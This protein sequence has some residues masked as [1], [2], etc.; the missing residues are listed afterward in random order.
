[1][2]VHN[3][4]LALFILKNHGPAELA[5]LDFSGRAGQLALDGGCRPDEV[6]VGMEGGVVIHGELGALVSG[7]HAPD[8]FLV[9]F[10]AVVFERRDIKEGVRA[11]RI[12]LRGVGGIERCPAVPDLLQVSLIGG[13]NGLRF[14]G[15]RVVDGSGGGEGDASNE[16]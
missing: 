15:S 10:P 16:N 8:A 9:F 12:E 11:G 3:Q 13:G 5:H 6:S 2:L 14:P 7:D 1:M 4:P